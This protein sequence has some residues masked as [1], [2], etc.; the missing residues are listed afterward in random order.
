MYVSQHDIAN[1]DDVTVKKL[2]LAAND[3]AE[4]PQLGRLWRAFSHALI[5][6]NKERR[7]LL[8]IAEAEYMNDDGAGCLV[9]PGTDPVA[10]ARAELRRLM[11]AD[12]E[13][14]EPPAHD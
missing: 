14:E 7:R 3:Q 1:L 10:E 9:E 13:R 2:V 8:L 4:D 12:I 6:A 11:R 5:R